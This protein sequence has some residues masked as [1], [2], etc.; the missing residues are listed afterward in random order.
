[1]LLHT[2]LVAAQAASPPPRVALTWEAPAGCPDR[3]AALA[4]LQHMLAGADAARTQPL[5]AGVVIAS[6]RPDAWTLRLETTTNGLRGQRTLNGRTCARVADA[7]LLLIAFAVAPDMAGALPTTV[8]RPARPMTVSLHLSAALHAEYGGLPRFAPGPAGRLALAFG[9][10]FGVVRV[11]VG[12]LY[13]PN[14]AT[15][16]DPLAQRALIARAAGD[17]RGCVLFG[18]VVS[19]GPCAGIEFGWIW[20]YGQNFQENY[21]AGGFWSVATAGALGRLALGSRVAL[22]VEIAA[23]FLL[24]GPT[25]VGHGVDLFRPLNVMARGAVAFEVRIF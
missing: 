20:G 24:A 19:G 13:L 16:D 18:G 5:T 1:V 9:L 17:A 23:G 15:S 14:Q 4:T 8:R 6:D 21:T 10:P 12:G 22:K 11:E 7:A 3:A 2:G 25:F